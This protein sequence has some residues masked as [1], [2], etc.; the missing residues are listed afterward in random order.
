[1]GHEVEIFTNAL[2][3]E[4]FPEFFDKVKINVF[5]YPLAGKLPPEW[6]PHLIPPKILQTEQKV[7]STSYLRKQ[8][9]RIRKLW[10]GFY[11]VNHSLTCS[12]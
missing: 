2:N 3:E 10:L 6:I 8:M 4:T 11:Y 5:P 12:N 9:L 1:M 7:G